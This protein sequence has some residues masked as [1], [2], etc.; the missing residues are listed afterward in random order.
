MNEE[1][2]FNRIFKY[3]INETY[4]NKFSILKED[5]TPVPLSYEDFLKWKSKVDIYGCY[6]NF[7][8]LNSQ[9]NPFMQRLTSLRLPITHHYNCLNEAFSGLNMFELL[10]PNAHD[11]IRKYTAMRIGKIL[12][13]TAH[14]SVNPVANACCYD[15]Q[16]H[17]FHPGTSLVSAHQILEQPIRTIYTV[18]KGLTPRHAMHSLK[19]LNTLYDFIDYYE[20]EPISFLS[21][22]RLH[23]FCMHDGYDELCPNGWPGSIAYDMHR[24]LREISTKDN[25]SMPVKL[26]DSDIIYHVPKIDD[27]QTFFE[28]LYKQDYNLGVK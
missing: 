3:Q 12:Y 1:I 27:V 17:A 28:W 16:S 6:V 4:K 23:M 26:Y 8:I 15:Q 7:T 22:D 25:D 20:N 18:K 5:N 2:L 9:Y 11:E 14:M 21:R 24:F 10:H 19:K 13:S